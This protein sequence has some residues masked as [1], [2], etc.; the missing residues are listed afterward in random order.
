MT[1]KNLTFHFAAMTPRQANQANECP[2]FVGYGIC[3][4][5]LPNEKN[6]ADFCAGKG[7]WQ[8]KFLSVRFISQDGKRDFIFDSDKTRELVSLFA[9]LRPTIR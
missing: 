8:Y 3:E 7:Y 2:S 5:P 4:E 9:K 1:V 6:T